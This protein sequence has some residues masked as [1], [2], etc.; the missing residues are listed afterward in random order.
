[1][2]TKYTLRLCVEST[3][4]HSWTP[5][6]ETCAGILPAAAWRNAIKAWC[7]LHP[8]PD[9]YEYFIPLPRLQR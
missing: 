4:G 8:L 2:D 1:V 9:G 6:Q 7:A 3:T 5:L